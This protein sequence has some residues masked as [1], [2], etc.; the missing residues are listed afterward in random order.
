MK[1]LGYIYRYNDEEQMGIL[2]YGHKSGPYWVKPILFTKTDCLSPIKTGQLVY[3]DLLD[4]KTVNNIE[5]ASL[6]NF[7]KDVVED[8]VSCYDNKHKIEWYDITHIQFEDI[9]KLK[10]KEIIEDSLTSK[11]SENDLTLLSENRNH[12][13]SKLFY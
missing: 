5:R 9:S 3:F 13:L 6:S 2:A 12:I 10:V 7:K 4:D 1:T 11:D 8:L